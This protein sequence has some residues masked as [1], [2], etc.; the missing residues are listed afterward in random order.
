MV[1]GASQSPVA[2]FGLTGMARRFCMSHP[3]EC[4][5]S[6]EVQQFATKL[7][8]LLGKK[9]SNDAKEELKVITVL[10]ALGNFG[11]MTPEARTAVSECVKES[12]LPVTIRLA[13][14]EASR[15]NPCDSQVFQSLF[16][17]RFNC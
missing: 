5:S 16:I 17:K 11:I 1:E 12:K 6:P 2:L 7:G 4:E 8:K 13:A 3:T 14:I 15:S 10:K 9:C